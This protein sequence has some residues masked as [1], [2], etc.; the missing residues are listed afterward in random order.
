MEFDGQKIMVVEDNLMSYKLIEAH[1][2]RKNLQ[3]LHAV[4]GYQAL[5][6]FRSDDDIR[7]I[8]MDIQLPRLSGLEVT[9]LIR[10][11]DQDVPIIA[12]T[13]NAF[14]EDRIACKEAGCTNFITKPINFNELFDL[15]KEYL[16]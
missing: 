5:E 11:T 16:H 7:I 3:L 9:R 8:L 1:L 4:D 10:E 14:D 13:A 2:Q 6:L 12:T 15:L